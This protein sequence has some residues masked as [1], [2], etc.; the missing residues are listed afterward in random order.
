MIKVMLLYHETMMV[1]VVLMVFLVVLCS[2]ASLVS[3]IE[4]QSVHAD[5]RIQRHHLK[6]EDNYEVIVV[7]N[8]LN[9]E[10]LKEVMSL[11][12]DAADDRW[13]YS[14]NSGQ[15]GAKVRSNDNIFERRLVV[16][17]YNNHRRFSYSK[18]EMLPSDP[19]V[20][21]LKQLFNRKETMTELSSLFRYAN[22]K[23]KFIT[24]LFVAKYIHDDFLSW[25]GD[26]ASGSFAFV[27]GL[28]QDWNSSSDGG[29][30]QFLCDDS[31]AG[32]SDAICL[33]LE[34]A[35]NSLTI[36]RTRYQSSLKVGL[37]Q[38]PILHRVDRVRSDSKTRLTATGWYMC[39]DDRMNKEELKICS[40]LK[41]SSCEEDG[42]F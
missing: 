11:F 21:R 13:L 5:W 35:F 2:C 24:E 36:F 17:G 18:H 20:Q 4:S 6:P 3:S 27:L 40:E 29:S 16:E 1:V 34:P 9:S 41:G 32:G 12:G 39:A 15:N 14:T 7:N 26:G 31:N 10:D 22:V 28:T 30:L 38:T 19:I 23:A 25:H 8:F 33:D 37:P 42:E